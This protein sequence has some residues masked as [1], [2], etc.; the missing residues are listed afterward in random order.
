MGLKDNYREAE[1][2]KENFAFFGISMC[3]M[4]NRK[5][6]YQQLQYKLHE[7]LPWE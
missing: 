7:W 6:S 1:E 3:Y 5:Y 2:Q 4:H